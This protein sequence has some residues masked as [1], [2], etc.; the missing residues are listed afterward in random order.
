MADLS[1]AA[2]ANILLRL[3]ANALIEQHFA[4]EAAARLI[5]RTAKNLVGQDNVPAAGPF[6][7]WDPL[8]QSTI[9]EKAR[10]GYS[11]QVSA[12][13]PLLRTGHL[14]ASIEHVAGDTE[15]FIGSNLDEAVWQEVGT[16]HVPPRSYLGH[17]AAEKAPEVAAILGEFVVAAL[18]S[19]GR[20][21]TRL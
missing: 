16:S 14:C 20:P 9:D 7:A 5:E 6:P 12:T 2:F 1:L 11:G 18:L 21:P 4:L 8:A 17:A 3:P 13:D 10:L 19:Q 15:A